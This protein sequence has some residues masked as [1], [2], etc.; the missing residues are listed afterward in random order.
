MYINNLWCDNEGTASWTTIDKFGNDTTYSNSET[1]GVPWDGS[2]G[3]IAEL[4]S[5]Y[6]MYLQRQ[7]EMSRN[8]LSHIERNS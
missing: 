2:Q 1:F 3:E 8:L 4:T 6:I 7:L 5:T